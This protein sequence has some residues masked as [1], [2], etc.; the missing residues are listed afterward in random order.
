RLMKAISLLD[1]IHPAETSTLDIDAL[2]AECYAAMNDDFNSPIVMA[3]LFDGVRMINSL[4]DGK[5]T[6]D[7]QGLAKLKKLFNDFV[8]DILGL[9]GDEKEASG[10]NDVL[11][12]VVDL[13]LN[14]RLQAKAQKNWALA[15]QIRDE[16]TKL[17]FEIKDK[18]DGFEWEF[19]G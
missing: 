19:R 8:F 3:N 12:D 11:S 7:G 13:L 16:L 9:K 15:D 4:N 6:I 18:K 1:K 2:E 17:G 10:S 14:A 5:A